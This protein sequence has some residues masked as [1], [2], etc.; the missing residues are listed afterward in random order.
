MQWQR[1]IQYYFHL[2]PSVKKVSVPW[3][4]NNFS[5]FFLTSS[6]L[7]LLFRC[8]IFNNK[9]ILFLWKTLGDLPFHKIKIFKIVFFL[10][11][12]WLFNFF[13]FEKYFIFLLIIVFL[14]FLF[15]IMLTYWIFVR[16]LLFF[17]FFFFFLTFLFFLFLF[18]FC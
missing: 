7:S 3:N 15:V 2:I 12:N 9:L 4:S 13:P 16:F 18:L 8:K 5:S 1:Y 10:F 14:F 17:F 6:V 11:L